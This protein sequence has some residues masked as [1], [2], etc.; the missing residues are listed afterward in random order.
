MLQLASIALLLLVPAAAV[1]QTKA[2]PLREALTFE[3]ELDTAPLH[4]A[5][6]PNVS[7][8][9]PSGFKPAEP[10]NLVVFLHGLRGCLPVL[11][12]KGESRCDE[13]AERQLGWDLGAHHDQAGT[14]TILIVPRLYYGK[15]GGQPGAFGAD[16]G[17]AAFLDE[18][19]KG[20][21]STK[22]GRSFTRADVASITLLAHSAGYQTT[23]AILE[24]GA[25]GG[26]IHAV[27]L[28]DALYDFEDRYGRYA[29]AHA[30]DGFR[31]IAIQLRGGKPAKAGHKLQ[32][33]LLRALGEQRVAGA[34]PGELS[35]SI[36]EHAFVFADGRGPHAQVPQHHMAEVLR[37][38]DL[39]RR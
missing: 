14:N 6:T 35:A 31:L 9:V 15:R 39:P 33:R 25:V 2:A 3:A 19:L 28:F 32:R 8:H 11:M 30:A 26:L 18:L 24:H 10:L 20:P 12:G 1:A 23:L 16:G 29:L 4:L 7:V 34:R 22:L 17:F 27:V 13:H 5:A 36:A 21:L 37:A 38:L